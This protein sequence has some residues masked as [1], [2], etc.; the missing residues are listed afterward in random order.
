MIRIDTVWLTTQHWRA[1]R[2][3]QAMPQIFIGRYC[4]QGETKWEPRQFQTR[5][6][7]AIGHRNRTVLLCASRNQGLQYEQCLGS[8]TAQSVLAFTDL[9]WQRKHVHTSLR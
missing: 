2:N 8:A 7:K 5:V 4:E 3:V 9:C 6:A 1:G